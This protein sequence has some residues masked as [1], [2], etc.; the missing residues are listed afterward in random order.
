MNAAIS[1]GLDQL[2]RL[3]ADIVLMDLQYAPAVIT[4]DKK[5]KAEY[6]VGLIAT[7]AER[8]EVNVL[9]RF[10]L[11]RYWNVDQNVPFEQMISN[12]D[13]NELHQNNWSSDCIA[14]ALA[15]AI[16]EAATRTS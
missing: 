1:D 13:R 7:A 6:M 4:A 3:S 5:A 8:A 2:R 16:V 9:H 11:M 14:R 15:D 10:A 12:F